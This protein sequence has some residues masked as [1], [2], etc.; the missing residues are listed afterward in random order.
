LISDVPIASICLGGLDSNLITVIA[1]KF[2]PNI[3]IYHVSV[4]EK[5]YN[6]TYYAKILAEFLNSDIVELN[7]KKILKN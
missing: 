6:E 7:K 1:K 4:K 3:D 2:N 5:S